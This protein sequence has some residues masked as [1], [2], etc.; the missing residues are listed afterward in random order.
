MSSCSFVTLWMYITSIA[1]HGVNFLLVLASYSLLQ[2]QAG[3]IG[4]LKTWFLCLKFWALK[5]TTG[6]IASL[7]ILFGG[8]A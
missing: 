8:P 5:N 4:T 3:V 6:F 7:F 1:L 2:S